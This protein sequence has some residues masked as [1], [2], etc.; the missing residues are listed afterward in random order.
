MLKKIAIAAAV[1][2]IG[3]IALGVG[4]YEYA[5]EVTLTQINETAVESDGGT[6]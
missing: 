3:G 5:K 6:N 2:F 4:L 1:F